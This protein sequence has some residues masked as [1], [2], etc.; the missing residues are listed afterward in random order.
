[1][2]SYKELD[3]RMD[4]INGLREDLGTELEELKDDLESAND[5]LKEHKYQVSIGHYEYNEQMAEEMEQE[6]K[7][8]IE[9][10]EDN[11]WDKEKE[12]KEFDVENSFELSEI[13]SILNE[14]SRWDNLYSESELKDYIKETVEIPGNLYPYIDWDMLF[15]DYMA[16]YTIVEYQGQEYYIV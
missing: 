16:D 12:I 5:E 10:L 8:E 11:V 4:E 1:M 2:I 15:T 3:S 6:M 13:Q 9:R 7:L 14:I